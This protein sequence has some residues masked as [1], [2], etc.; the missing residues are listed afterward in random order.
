MEHLIKESIV[1]FSHRLVWVT[2]DVIR[3]FWFRSN[4]LAARSGRW[5]RLPAAVRGQ[6]LESA[7]NQA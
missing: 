5:A 6:T 1:D 4:A 3:S 7:E 2:L